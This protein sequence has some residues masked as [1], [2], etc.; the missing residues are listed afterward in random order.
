MATDKR[1][2]IKLAVE[3]PTTPKI[4]ILTDVAFRSYVEMLCY[5]RDH[6][7]DGFIHARIAQ[8]QWPAEAVEELCTNDGNRS[9][10]IRVENG[11]LIRDY[12][13]HQETRAKVE[14]RAEASAK[15]GRV[16]PNASGTS[17][18]T[19]SPTSSGTS[20]TTKARTS[21][22]T[23]ARTS[24]ESESESEQEK[25]K[26]SYNTESVSPVSDRARNAG[27]TDRG[28]ASII[29]TVNLHCDIDATEA[30]AVELAEHITSKAKTAPRNPAAY[31]RNAIER[32]PS[33]IDAWFRARRRHLKAVGQ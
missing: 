23:T 9:S 1:I 18:A 3:M 32:G 25:E 14:A 19:S 26:D 17:S 15:G 7:T 24:T 30:E 6:L 10:L 31:V 2:W 33:E 28:I 8:R 12:D 11:Y 13:K 5:S 22:T 20:G 4:A 27:L 21:S 29:S 16:K